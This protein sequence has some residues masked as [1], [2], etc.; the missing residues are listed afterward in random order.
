M[1]N[2]A[3]EL[4][5]VSSS[6]KRSACKMSDDIKPGPGPAGEGNGPPKRPPV[7]TTCAIPA[8]DG[9]FQICIATETD[10]SC[11]ACNAEFVINSAF[12]DAVAECPDCSTMFIIKEPGYEK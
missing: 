10:V 7:T 6:V 3:L 2:Q 12:Y 1:Y 11:P 4:T 8:D 9:G 5:D